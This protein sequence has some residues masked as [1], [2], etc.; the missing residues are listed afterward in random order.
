MRGRQ[1]GAACRQLGPPPHAAAAGPPLRPPHHPAAHPPPLSPGEHPLHLHGHQFWVM[2]RGA[3]NEGP[4]NSTIALNT[5]PLIR[6]TAT[7]EAGSYLVMRFV[8]SNPGVWM[9]Q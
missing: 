1:P 9:F 6:D 8:A 7:V 2:A 4:F 3:E 5:T